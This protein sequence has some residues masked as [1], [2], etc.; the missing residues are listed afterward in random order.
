MRPLPAGFE[1][2][3]RKTLRSLSLRAFSCSYLDTAV[4]KAGL[5]LGLAVTVSTEMSS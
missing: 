4:G 5:V 1:G 2:V 3:Q